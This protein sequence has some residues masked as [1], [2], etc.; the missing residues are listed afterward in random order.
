MKLGNKVVAIT[1]AGGIICSAF[2]KA[3]AE[4]KKAAESALSNA[5]VPTATEIMQ[6]KTAVRGVASLENKLYF[7]LKPFVSLKIRVYNF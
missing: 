1:G 2:A 4:E 5:L 3:L 7:L 6:V